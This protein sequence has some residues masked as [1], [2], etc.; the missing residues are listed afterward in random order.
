MDNIKQMNVFETLFASLLSLAMNIMPVI[1]TVLFCSFLFWFIPTLLGFLF[2]F[3]VGIKNGYY[4]LVN[5]GQF[6]S[7]FKNIKEIITSGILG[8]FSMLIV[9][10]L[11]IGAFL[12][13]FVS[14]L[15]TKLYK[16]K[17]K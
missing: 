8:G 6:N 4:F 11:W 17:K 2:G 1:K 9:C 12:Y 5:N 10:N 7:S 3:C 16:N 14:E 13:F 15:I